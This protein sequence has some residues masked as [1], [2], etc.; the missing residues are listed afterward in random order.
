MSKETVKSDV[1]DEPLVLA[2]GTPHD[3]FDVTE[4]V[5]KMRRQSALLS[6]ERGHDDDVLDKLWRSRSR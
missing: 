6:I 4:L 5:R 3:R 2:V 1:A